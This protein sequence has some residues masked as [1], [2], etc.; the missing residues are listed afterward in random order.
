MGY[1]DDICVK[2]VSS[3]E[4]LV[5]ELSNQKV[6]QKSGSNWSCPGW[7]D[8]FD[9]YLEG[10]LSSSV[11]ILTTE[12]EKTKYINHSGDSIFVDTPKFFVIKRIYSQDSW[13][14]DEGRYEVSYYVIYV[15]GH[16]ESAL[17]FLIN[18]VIE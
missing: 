9:I 15:Q 6:G 14:N 5:K 16:L 17:R 11:V 2:E 3:Y 10:K 8:Q 7:Y 13:D 12:D 4:E 18:R 1:I